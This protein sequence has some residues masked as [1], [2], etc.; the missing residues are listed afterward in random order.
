MGPHYMDVYRAALN[1]NP[2]L[3]I[4]YEMYFS[5]NEENHIYKNVCCV[6]V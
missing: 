5:S 2:P 1:N 4:L 3:S 6:H